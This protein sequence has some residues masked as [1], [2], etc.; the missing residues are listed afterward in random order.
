[1]LTELRITDFAIIHDLRLEFG[2]RFTVF[3]GETGAGKSIIIDAVELLLGG[4]A[5]SS[6]LREGADLALVEGVFTIDLPEVQQLLERE[7]LLDDPSTVV[8]A[9][10]IRREGRN[11]CRINGRVVTLALVRSLGE[12]LV[13]VHGQSEHLSLLRVKEHLPILD[14]FADLDLTEYQ[15]VYQRYTSVRRELDQL[16]SDERD[17]ARREDLLRYQINEIEAA[18]L[19]PEELPQLEAERDRLANAEKLAGMA[20]NAL[21]ALEQDGEGGGAA[22]DR[23]ADTAGAL[24]GLAEIDASMRQLAQQAQGLSEEASQLAGE[25]QE[26]LE[27]AQPDPIRLDEVEARLGLIHDLQRKYGSDLPAVLAYA[28][29]AAEELERVVHSEQRLAELRGE[30]QRLLPQLGSLGQQLSSWRREAGQQLAQQIVTDLDQLQMQGAQFEVRID[31]ED[32]PDGVPL[33]D[34]RIAFGPLGLDQ[35]DLVAG[36]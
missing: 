6:L 34:R 3:T 11:L 23:L 31:W 18:A 30:Q 36:R 12:W 7:E 1:M 20:L 2:P 8:L 21:A 9:R 17:R 13:D 32:D 4:R 16:Q 14:R 24:L 19:D 28:A 15:A 22:V 5:D 25:L 33:D 27:Q 29:R 26:Y 10:E 35:A